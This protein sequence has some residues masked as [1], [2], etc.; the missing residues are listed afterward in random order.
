MIL[1]D[2]KNIFMPMARHAHVLLI[3]ILTVFF[4]KMVDKNVRVT[5]KRLQRYEKLSYNI[6]DEFSGV[7]TIEV[8]F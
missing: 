3:L 4:F 1:E 5:N 8:F 2:L 7:T 6:Y